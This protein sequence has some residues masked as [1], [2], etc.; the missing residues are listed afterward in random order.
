MNYS[1]NYGDGVTAYVK[2]RNRKK[3]WHHNIS[4][5]YFFYLKYPRLQFNISN[6]LFTTDPNYNIRGSRCNNVL[7]T[8][9]SI[10]YKFSIWSYLTVNKKYII[11]HFPRVVCGLIFHIWFIN[12]YNNLFYIL[13]PTSWF[14]GKICH[15]TN[16]TKFKLV[17]LKIFLLDVIQVKKILDILKIKKKNIFLSIS[18]IFFYI[19]LINFW[20][21][22]S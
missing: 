6:N 12:C 19:I 11:K 9:L 7:E 10:V 16:Y 20:R 18:Y 4:R 22:K 21:E 14:I 13:V 17:P 1:S 15:Y 2:Y 5:N 3:L 8:I